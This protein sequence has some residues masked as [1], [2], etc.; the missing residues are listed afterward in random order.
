[1]MITTSTTH[2]NILDQIL[3][4]IT[5]NRTRNITFHIHYEFEKLVHGDLV[6]ESKAN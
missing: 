3:A 1:M 4:H 2:P 5:G 6:I